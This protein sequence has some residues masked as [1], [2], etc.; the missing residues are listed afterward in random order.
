MKTKPENSNFSAL[1]NIWDSLGNKQGEI[2]SDE[3]RC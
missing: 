3:V 2:Y 1:Q